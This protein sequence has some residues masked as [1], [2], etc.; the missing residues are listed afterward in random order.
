LTF[1]AFDSR[2]GL[3]AAHWDQTPVTSSYLDEIITVC[4]QRLEEIR[5]RIP[6]E[7][8][9]QAVE[10]RHERRDFAGALSGD[11]LRVIAELKKASPSRG[12]L[13]AAYRCRELAQG[14]EAGGAAALSVLTEERFFHGSLTDLIDAR[15][16]VGLPVLR[17]DFILDSYQVYESAA[18][19]ADALLLIVTALSDMVLRELIELCSRLQMAALVEVHT[20]EDVARALDAGARIIGVNNRDLQTFKVTL[21]TSL[22]L[23]DKIPW[24]CLAVSE[25]GI[26]VAG[27]LLR[28]RQA[29]YH[30]VLIGEKLMTAADP[31]AALAGLMEEAQVSQESGVRSQKPN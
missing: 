22:R 12:L 8:L 30:A 18:A 24:W 25:S 6:L 3:N 2:N 16:A 19:N 9:Q 15:D 31:G 23:R 28:L 4:Q 5:T 14:Y 11:G 26:R 29:G 1:V 21:E 17:K 13:R 20:E 7:Q 10:A 27:D